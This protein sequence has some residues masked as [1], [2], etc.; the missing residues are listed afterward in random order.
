MR[1]AKL[2]QAVDAFNRGDLSEAQTLAEKAVAAEPSPVWEHLLGL[3]HC[4][5]GDAASGVEWLCRACDG[6]PGNLGFR[7]AAARALIDSGRATEVLAMPEPPQITSGAVLALW[8]ARAEAA[9]VTEDFVASEVS[10]RAVTG[11]SPGDWRAWGNLGNALAAQ[12][13]WEDAAEALRQ[14]VRLSPSERLLWRNLAAALAAAERHDD[15]LRVL[16]DWARA[17]GASAEQAIMRGASLF[18]VQRFDEAET[19]YKDALE[20][21]PTDPQA[22]QGLGHVYERTG[23]ADRIG[24]LVDS[25]A[26]AGVALGELGYLPAIRAMAEGRPDE[27]DEWLSTVDCRGDPVRWYRLKSRI[28]DRLG[29]PAEAFAAAEAMNRSTAEFEEWVRRAAQYRRRLRNIAQSI[30]GASA[31]SALAP[32]ELT[33]VFL[34]GFPRSGT[35]LLDTF[36]MGHSRISV[37]EELPLIME[38]EKICPVE[39]AG[40]CSRET[41]EQAREAYLEGLVGNIDGHFEGVV[42]DKMPLN[43]LAVPL[44]GALFPHARFIFAQRHPCDAVLSGF[45]QSFVASEPMASFLTIEGAADFY[46]AAMTLW[47][48]CTQAFHLDC[49]TVVYEQL[50]D[51]PESALKPL[52]EFLGVTWEDQM[53]DHRRTARERGAIVTPSYDQVVQPLS[54][55]AVGRWKLYEPQLKPVLPALLPW[56]ERLGY[57]EH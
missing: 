54:K 49:H 42:V 17:R 11:A 6:E 36:L 1:S 35:T 40:T 30:E 8:Q 3:I 43:M 23:R 7:V 46:D 44:I 26:A 53:L 2:N 50:V 19:A 21:A 45:M 14:A 37:L 22:L 47:T 39:Q 34:V 27:A 5:R 56:A 31:S 18:A 25:A 4:R 41:L 55:E 38:A 12:D 28:A 10:W 33:P 52:I 15:T 57:P 48:K 24:E 16:E 32:A 9:D 13:R 20:S 51:E 29:E